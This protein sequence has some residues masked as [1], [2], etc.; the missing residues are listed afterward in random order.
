MNTILA[1]ASAF[2]GLI[3]LAAVFYDG[4]EDTLGQRVGLAVMGTSMYP[5]TVQFYENAPISTG[6]KVALGCGLV[7]FILATAVKGAAHAEP[8]SAPTNV[9]H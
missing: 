1:A 4:F 3:C 5:I 9:P 8:G 2:A 6:A 7:L